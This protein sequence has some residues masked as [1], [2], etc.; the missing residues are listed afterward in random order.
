MRH[1]HPLPD[2]ALAVVFGFGS[3]K[4]EDYLTSDPYDRVTQQ[5]RDSHTRGENL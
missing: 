3:A 5:I 4:R 1:E 2:F